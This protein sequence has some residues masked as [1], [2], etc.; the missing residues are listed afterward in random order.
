M[1]L[2]G[3]VGENFL[4]KP[5]YPM[6]K[7]KILSIFTLLGAVRNDKHRVDSK[8]VF[9]FKVILTATIRLITN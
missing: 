3:I 5:I 1:T 4:G 2:K 9:I 7:F 8:V 6:C